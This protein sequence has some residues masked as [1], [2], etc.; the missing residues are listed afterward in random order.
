M[1]AV[2]TKETALDISID[3]E[4][5]V[6]AQGRDPITGDPRFNAKAIAAMEEA[7]A[8]MR[9]EI[10]SKRYKPHEFEQAVEDLLED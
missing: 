10:P 8:I 9:G 7:R 3:D 2:L 6:Y 1:N 5:T 4:S